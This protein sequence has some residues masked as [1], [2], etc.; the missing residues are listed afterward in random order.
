MKVTVYVASTK[1]SFFPDDPIYTPIQ[2]GKV[3]SDEKFADITDATGENISAKNK[4]YCELTALYWMWKNDAES[5]YLGLCHYRRYFASGVYGKKQDRIMSGD[6][7]KGIIEK[8]RDCAIVPYKRNY[9]FDTLAS[10]YGFTLNPNH[11]IVARD[12]ITELEPS[13]IQS[14]DKTMKQHG[15]H[16]FNMFVMSREYVSE[17]C[18]WLFPLLAELEKRIDTSDMSEFE[19]RVFGR[20]SELLFNVWLN[21]NKIKTVSIG[22][23]NLTKTDW[24]G[25]VSSYFAAKFRGKKLQHSY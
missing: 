22:Y 20:L 1:P 19:A 7:L 18:G 16:M 4:T 11:I 24:A 17:Y 14:F 8:H 25:K 5:D 12:V 3:F 13:Y 10:H 2:V 9:G 6:K 21:R 15:A 23:V